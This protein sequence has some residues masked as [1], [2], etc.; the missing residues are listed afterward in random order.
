MRSYRS[1]LICRVLRKEGWGVRSQ[2]SLLA[3]RER[4][5]RMPLEAPSRAPSFYL[6]NGLFPTSVLRER[7]RSLTTSAWMKAGRVYQR[8]DE[9][10]KRKK[11]R[12]RATLREE[13]RD[14]ADDDLDAV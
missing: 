13:R 14:D 6:S 9:G 2:F 7:L 8:R 12:G 1:G 10:R 5:S 3:Y 4:T 11:L